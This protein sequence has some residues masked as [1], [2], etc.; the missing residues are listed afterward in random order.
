M[1]GG[2]CD[3]ATREAIETLGAHGLR[4]DFMRVRGFPFGQAVKD[5]VAAHERIFVVEQNRDGQLRTLLTTELDIDGRKL[6]SVL[7]YGGFP[8]SARHVV[9]SIRAQL[10]PRETTT[11][12][13][14]VK[15]AAEKSA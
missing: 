2:G 5:F 13:D 12:V 3:A 6:T 8:L 9:E 10:G 14:R 1:R 11:T 7:F 15:A 4:A